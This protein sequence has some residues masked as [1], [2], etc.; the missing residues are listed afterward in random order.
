MNV[1]MK[2]YD[3]RFR[4][5]KILRQNGMREHNTPTVSSSGDTQNEQTE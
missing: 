1:I 5:I 4:R 3:G 2:D